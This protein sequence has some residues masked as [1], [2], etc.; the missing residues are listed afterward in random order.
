MTRR[1]DE[2][3]TPA[4]C[5]GDVPVL[6]RRSQGFE[7]VAVVGL[8]SREGSLAAGLIDA[9]VSPAVSIFEWCLITH[10]IFASV[11]SSATVCC[12]PL[13]LAYRWAACS[14]ADSLSV[15]SQ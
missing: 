9:W 4:T 7:A 8:L 5:A 15:Q 6:T 11:D 1:G 10:V 12:G 13:T 2:V 14:S 3:E